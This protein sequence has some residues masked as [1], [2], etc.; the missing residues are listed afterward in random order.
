M[1]V[2]PRTMNMALGVRILAAAATILVEIT[3]DCEIK[4]ALDAEMRNN[5]ESPTR[6]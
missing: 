5:K 4:K 3:G 2:A 6:R 1:G